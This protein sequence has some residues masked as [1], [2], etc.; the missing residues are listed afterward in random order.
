M[1]SIGA[2]SATLLNGLANSGTVSL[3]GG[4]IFGPGN[5]A[6]T[7]TI[8]G[9]GTIAPTL[10]NSGTVDVLG[11]TLALNFAPVQNGRVNIASDGTLSVGASWANAGVISLNSGRLMTTGNLTNLAGG[12][13]QGNG[14]IGG[15][16][17]NQG[18]L[19]PGFS[20]GALT[21]D[22]DLT[23]GSGGTVIIELSSLSSFDKVTV[24]GNATLDGNL[25][26][27]LLGGYTP[28]PSDSWAILT[29]TAGLSGTFASV[30][31]GYV[32]QIVGNDLVLTAVPETSTATFC[33]GGILLLTVVMRRRRKA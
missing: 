11:G 5:V 6:N 4:S 29:A 20:V 3:G 7:G 2:S 15:N 31:A 32:W 28:N 18:T 16:L 13:I 26:I 1:F 8:S 27:I 21:L 9:F 10:N 33:V 19:S 25:Q 22:N 14:T 12:L 17:I 24:A 30:T 23:L